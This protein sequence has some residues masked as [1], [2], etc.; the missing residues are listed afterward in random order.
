MPPAAVYCHYQQECRILGGHPNSPIISL[1]DHHLR[2]HHHRDVDMDNVDMSAD[3]SAVIIMAKSKTKRKLW[4]RQTS[5]LTEKRDIE[6]VASS[7]FN[8]VTIKKTSSIFPV[9]TFHQNKFFQYHHQYQLIA[10]AHLFLQPCQIDRLYNLST[11]QNN[12]TSP[13][14]SCRAFSHR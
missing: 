1:Q 14:E 7:S 2:H 9:I 13:L 10:M 3:Q 12:R 4:R 5:S 6:T 8:L 11:E